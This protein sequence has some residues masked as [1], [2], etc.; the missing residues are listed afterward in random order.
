MIKLSFRYNPKIYV[1]FMGYY[2][3]IIVLWMSFF[4]ITVSVGADDSAC[5]TCHSDETKKWSISH[6]AKAMSL[7]DEN[8]VLGNFQ[9]TTISHHGQSVTFSMEGTSYKVAIVDEGHPPHSYTIAYTFGVTPL[10]QYLVETEQGRYQVLPFAWDSRT[11]AEGGERWF[12]IYPDETLPPGDRLHWQQPLQNWNGM[13]ADCH[14]TGLK[15][16]YD[17]ISNQ[18]KTS[19]D[20]VNVSCSSCHAGAPAHAKARASSEPNDQALKDTWKD[21]LVS[22]LK[23]NEG[24]VRQDGEPTAKYSGKTPRKRP[25]MQVCAACHSRRGPLTDGI[26]PSLKFLDQ[27]SPSLLDD[28]LY[29]PDGQIED[30]VYV[31]GSFQQSKM[32]QKGVSCFDCHDSH[33]LKLKVEDNKLCTQCHATDVFDRKEHHRHEQD[34]QGA[35]CVSCHMPQRTYMVVD[36]RRDHSFKVPRPD[37]SSQTGS[38]NVCVTCHEDKNNKWAAQQLKDWYPTSKHTGNEAVTIRNARRGHPTSRSGLLTIIENEQQS[39]IL[40]A[41]ALSLIPRV[42]DAKLIDKAQQYLSHNEPLMRIGAIRALAVLL[43]EQRLPALAP[44]LTD[45][46]KAVRV[47]AAR[48]LLDT[49]DA[50]T[51]EQAFDEL[52]QINQQ[53]GWRGES[54]TNLALAHEVLGEPSDAEKEYRKSLEIDPAFAPATINLSELLRRTGRQ[55]EGFELLQRSINKGGNIDPSLYHAY[56][57]ALVRKGSSRQ[58]LVPLKKAM[59]E[60]RES[61]RYAYVYLVA[62]NSLGKSDEAYRGLKSALRRHRY[63]TNMLNFALSLAMQRRDQAY[64]RSTVTALLKLD[65]SNLDYQRLLVQLK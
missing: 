24:F 3:N 16:N 5:S 31:W 26:D 33:S 1:S 2:T 58:A 44:L 65:P 40:R 63:D 7:A 9:N 8:S 52:K 61:A 29:F 41:T 10:Q 13:C 19:F 39:T 25:E 45:T 54:R 35:Q 17:V 60:A 15:R 14:S 30:E 42:A 37:M 50:R 28:G 47:E 43:P 51:V 36:P 20:T 18:F 59:L 62:L 57:L 21:S 11:K 48:Q 46:V 53:G 32:F 38:P 23:D 55:Q 64:A 34:T 56:G 4:A 49:L 6:H 27:F 12:H 22:Y